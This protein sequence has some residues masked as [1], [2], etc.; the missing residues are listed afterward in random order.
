[1]TTKVD[2]SAC[3]EACKTCAAQCQAC[4]ETCRASGKEVSSVSTA[5]IVLLFVRRAL[6]YCLLARSLLLNFVACVQRFAVP[7]P[8]LARHTKSASAAHLVLILAIS[9]RKSATR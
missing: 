9:V 2:F 7:V 8:K 4:I 6:N 1:M 5:V 3:L